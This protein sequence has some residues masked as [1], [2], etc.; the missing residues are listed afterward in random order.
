MNVGS[1]GSRGSRGSGGS[2]GV[3]FGVLASSWLAVLVCAG[4]VNAQTA[5]PLRSIDKGAQSNLDDALQATARSAAEW[6]ALWKKHDYDKPAPPVDFSKEMILA[7]FMGSRPSAGF[8]LEIVSAAVKDGALV[9]TYRETRPT[10]GTVSAQILTAP[11]HIVAVPAR[12][13]PV[14]FQ[15]APQE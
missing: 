2:L 8:S 1:G 4:P 9:V 7:V 3:V 15:K 5:Q 14:S 13:G 6:S 12:A 11:Y 10:S